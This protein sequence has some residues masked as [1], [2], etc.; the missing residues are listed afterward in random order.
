MLCHLEQR[1]ATPSNRRPATGGGGGGGGGALAPNKKR[2]PE[3]AESAT[4]DSQFGGDLSASGGGGGSFTPGVGTN[5][6]HSLQT[7]SSF[8]TPA[9]A[10]AAGAPA[11]S[12]GSAAFGPGAGAGARAPRHARSRSHA[13]ALGSGLGLGVVGSLLDSSAFLSAA[14]GGGALLERDDELM[15]DDDDA[16]FDE[17]EEGQQEEERASDDGNEDEEAAFAAAAELQRQE[18]EAQQRQELQAAAAAHLTALFQSLCECLRL[19]SR[20]ECR[21]ALAQLECLSAAHHHSHFAQS[22]QGRCHFELH[23]YGPAADA[24]ARARVATPG[25]EKLAG[26]EYY[27]SALW[28][29]GAATELSALALALAEE[30]AHAPETAMVIGNCF[31]LARAHD[32]ALKFFRRAVQADPRCAYAYTLGAH[33]YLAADE[34]AQALRAYRL[35]LGADPRAYAAWYGLGSL[36]LRQEKV[37]QALAHF[38][39]AIAVHPASSVLRTCEGMALQAGRQWAPALEAFSAAQRLDPANPLPLYHI[40]HVHLAQGS[41][42][43]ALA[44]LVRLR[45]MVPREANVHLLLGRA[46]K[47]A[48]DLVGAMSSFV[49]AL[50]LDPRDRSAVKAAIEHVHSNDGLDDEDED[51]DL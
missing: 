29:R 31:S 25:C 24:Y 22:L 41:L 8:A 3:I 15:D 43:A 50:E 47:R 48:G 23:E 33:E 30:D 19:Q 2:L 6:L 12:S 7:P 5:L 1:K 34:P 21:A 9:N 17:E 38:R 27:S 14:D 10:P 49:T 36:F 4:P 16:A 32:S 35:A 51:A 46:Q 13:S 39:A 18:Q 44:I 20:Y 42:A 28:Q 37:A 26:L 40:A 45:E 11:S